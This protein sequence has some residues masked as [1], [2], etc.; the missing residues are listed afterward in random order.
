MKMSC[1]SRIV[2]I[3]IDS[4]LDLPP[5]IPY[6]LRLAQIYP[7]DAIK[8][9]LISTD[10]TLKEL[11]DVITKYVQ[12][13]YNYIGLP[14][15]ARLIDEFFASGLARRWPKVEFMIQYYGQPMD[16]PTNV[17]F[18][19]DVNTLSDPSLIQHN[20]TQFTEGAGEVYVIYQ[21]AGE[22][23]STRLAEEARQALE[24]LGVQAIF[25]EIGAPMNQIDDILLKE[26][27]DDISLSL[28]PRPSRSTVIHIINWN[29]AEVYTQAALRAGLFTIHPE[30]LTHASFQNEY[31]PV[32]TTLP[33]PLQLG[34]IPLRGLPSED[35]ARIGMPLDPPQYYSFPYFLSY[36][37]SYMWASHCGET[38]G[39]N[40]KQ[41]K[42]D[43]YRTRIC[44]FLANLSIPANRL[45]VT[46]GPAKF[47]PRWFN[48]NLR[49]VPRR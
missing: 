15:D 11:T 23:V 14:S 41:L 39:I 19:T 5:M 3:G 6:L 10:A 31:Y 48:E 42:F 7:S 2:Y 35:A 24:T 49:V 9:E 36:L 30:I 18:F 17:H 20:L 45:V 46:A 40:D 47:N 12:D 25:Y 26:A 44:Y 13:G 27:V 33:V 29:N 32:D 38:D 8:F 34:T 16:S 43:R 21:G 37:D 22:P 4:P 1:G 28:P